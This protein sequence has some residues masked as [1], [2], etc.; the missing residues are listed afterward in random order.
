MTAAARLVGFAETGTPEWFAMREGKITGSRIAACVGLSPWVSPFTLY[1]QLKGMATESVNTEG[2][3]WIEWGN[4]LEPVVIAH[5]ARRHPNVR[6][7]TRKTVWQNRERP[8]QQISPDA[9]FLRPGA[10]HRGRPSDGLLE[11]KTSQY[12]DDWGEPGSAD[13]PIHIRCQIIWMLDTLGLDGCH[14]AALF[15]GW[16]Y[17]EYYVPYD[18]D[19]ALIL[20]AAAER[21]LQRVAEDDRPDIDGEDST[22]QLIKTF[23]PDIDGSTVELPPDL[24][25][26]VV[27]AQGQLS[28]AEDTLATVRSTLAEYMGRAKRA[29]YGGRKFADRRSKNGGTP[30][31]Q[32][33]DLSSKPV[34]SQRKEVS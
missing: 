33:A 9:L 4:L 27:I 22:Y 17:Q 5:W 6:M 18:Q 15:S 14:V 8:W 1:Y 31:V 34:L 25:E 10:G 21:M 30:Y 29:E 13:V 19:D 20:R 2:S 12:K 23:H 26:Q 28:E 11:V 16:D 24:A 7:R 3:P 32:F